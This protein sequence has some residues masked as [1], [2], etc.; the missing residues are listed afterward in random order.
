MNDGL[1]AVSLPAA[2]LYLTATMIRVDRCTG[3]LSPRP[4]TVVTIC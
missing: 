1:E 2:V 4:V 3:R